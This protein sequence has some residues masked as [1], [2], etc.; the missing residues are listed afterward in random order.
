MR[1]R[2]PIQINVCNTSFVWTRASC[3]DQ[4]DI[5]DYVTSVVF[6]VAMMIV[7]ER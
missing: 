6:N 5:F 4:A 1:D 2:N 7:A 3:A